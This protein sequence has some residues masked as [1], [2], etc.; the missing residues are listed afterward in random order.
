MVYLEETKIEQAREDWNE[1]SSKS[2]PRVHWDDKI[3]QPPMEEKSFQISF[4]SV[5][6]EERKR[7]NLHAS[8]EVKDHAELLGENIPLQHQKA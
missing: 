3:S 4:Q 2:N 1:D 7:D 5:G 8:Q 6:I